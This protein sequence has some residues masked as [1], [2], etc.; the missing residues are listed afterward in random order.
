MVHH[1]QFHNECLLASLTMLTGREY[2]EASNAFANRYGVAW[3]HV[4]TAS[5]YWREFA[6][7]YFGVEI[8]ADV[9]T[10]YAL[11]PD[12]DVWTKGGVMVWARPIDCIWHAVAYDAATQTVYDPSG[13]VANFC[14]FQRIANM[15][16]IGS[17]T[18]S[19]KGYI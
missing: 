10:P 13:T 6:L 17:F 2:T 15:Q 16:F 8:P 9:L 19:Y 1:R 4:P 5:A 7:D 14:D 18:L 3:G 12:P 11:R